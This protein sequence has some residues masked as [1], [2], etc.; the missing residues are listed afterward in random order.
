MKQSER[1]NIARVP[2]YVYLTTGVDRKVWTIYHWI[3]VGIG[4]I[5][6]KSEKIC[7]QLFTRPEWVNEFLIKVG[8]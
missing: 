2:E 4:G 1:F 7:G 5:K 8:K 3:N 6:L